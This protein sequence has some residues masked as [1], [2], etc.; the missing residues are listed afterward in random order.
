[1]FEGVD[2]LLNSTGKVLSVAPDAYDDVLKPAAK[3]SG[4]T[5]SLIPRTINAALIPLQQW[6]ANKEF[7]LAE[8]EKLLAIK[9][10][11]VGEDKIVTPEPYVAI[12]ALQAISYSMNSEELREMY[13]NLLAKSMNKDTKDFVHPSFVEI[14]KQMSPND[15]NIFKTIFE[16]PTTPLIDLFVN[17]DNGGGQNHHIYNI[18]WIALC[19]HVTITIALNNLLRLGLIEIPYG[20]NYN[21]D[22]NYDIVRITEY[23]KNSKK[24]LE[25]LDLGVVTEGKKYIK[26]TALASSFYKI[27]ITE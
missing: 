10:E 3:E 16:S 7:N 6:I 9:L 18:S 21:L 11:H 5:L 19:D 2:N 4:R 13:A 25:S 26:K 15:A 14:I 12:P 20:T 22:S 23:Y 27:C 17:L 1:M 8:T 24:S